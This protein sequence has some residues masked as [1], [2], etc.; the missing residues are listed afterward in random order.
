MNSLCKQ[1]TIRILPAFY[2]S[3]QWYLLKILRE[4]WS[5]QSQ[6]LPARLEAG[7]I[8]WTEYDLLV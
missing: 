8:E 6:D 1:S 3:F 5:E 2:I 7:E 4:V